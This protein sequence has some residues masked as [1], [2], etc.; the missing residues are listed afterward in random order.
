[1]RS[2]E[3]SDITGQTVSLVP[4]QRA[5]LPILSGPLRGTKW[6]PAS[7]GKILRV[8]TGSYEP[9][10][11]RLF[12]E[13]IRPGDT[14]LDVGAAAGYYTLLTSGLVGPQGGVIAFEPDSRNAA[15]LRNHVEAN[16]ID[17]VSVFQIAVGAHDETA[18]FASGTGTGT[19]HLADDGTV[20]VQVRSLDN[21]VLSQHHRPSHIKIDV[22]GAELAVIEG[23]RKTLQK[24]R[25]V[26]FLSTHGQDVHQ[27]CC[28]RLRELGYDLAP[29]DSKHLPGATEVLCRAA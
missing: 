12:C 18:R 15:F 20:S 19:G 10:Q 29:I 17:N 22:E 3:V 23:A 26:I 8:L 25:P 7:G 5:W 24:F 27:A 13:S 6:L 16:R 9:A 28:E 4:L 21:L 11:T 14:V 1:M 2:S